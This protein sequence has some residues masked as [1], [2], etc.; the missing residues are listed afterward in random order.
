MHE[1]IEERSH[2]FPCNCG[3]CICAAYIKREKAE[4]RPFSKR[5]LFVF[6]LSAH[7]FQS[8]FFDQRLRFAG[9]RIPPQGKDLPYWQG[10]AV[11]IAERKREDILEKEG[12]DSF[13]DIW[14]LEAR[15]KQ[16]I[17]KKLDATRAADIIEERIRK[18]AKKRTKKFIERILE[19]ENSRKGKDFLRGI[20]QKKCFYTY[21]KR[22][23]D[24]RLPSVIYSLA[25]REK[26]N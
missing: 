16:R 22:A 15:R 12:V 9:I 2:G 24:P 6:F 13:K 8:T 7:F 11:K 18:T 21:Y 1:L 3:A 19:R 23:A 26:I 5:T 4:G 10:S 14:K 17:I 20:L 25:G